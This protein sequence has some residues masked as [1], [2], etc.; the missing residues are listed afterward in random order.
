MK[1]SEEALDCLSDSEESS[2]HGD[3]GQWCANATCDDSEEKDGLYCVKTVSR[4][5]VV[6]VDS[7]SGDDSN[8]GDETLHVL[9]T[10]PRRRLSPRR[11]KKSS[12]AMD[13]VTIGLLVAL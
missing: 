13:R 3:D 4:W 6:A 8:S 10:P 7:S 1:V 2:D 5:S 9:E 11:A 12:R